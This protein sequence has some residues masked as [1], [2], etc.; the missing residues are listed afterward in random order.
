MKAIQGNIHQQ[1]QGSN[2]IIE[3]DD[4]QQSF[5]QESEWLI[6]ITAFINTD[7]NDKAADKKENVN[8]NGSAEAGKR[9][10]EVYKNYKQGGNAPEVLDGFKAVQV[11]RIFISARKY[12]PLLSSLVI[13]Q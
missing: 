4:P 5:F 13:R 7:K 3:G 6:M 8:A 10:G 2:E 11:L 12:F 9:C 1:K